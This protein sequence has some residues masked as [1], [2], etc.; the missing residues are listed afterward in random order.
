MFNK[1]V[2]LFLMILCI[3]GFCFSIWHLISMLQTPKDMRIWYGVDVVMQLLYPFYVAG[4]AEGIYLF[5]L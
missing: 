2:G 4:I 3:L 5:T 1:I